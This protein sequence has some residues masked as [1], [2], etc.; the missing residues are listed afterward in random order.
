MKEKDVK[1]QQNFVIESFSDQETLSQYSNDALNI[2]LWESE[3]IFFTKYFPKDGR[4]LDIGCG[5]GR[6]TFG[7]YK[8]GYKNIIGVDLTPSM[9]E[10]ARKNSKKMGIDIG[11]EIGDACNL[12]YKDNS[13]GGCIFSFNGIMQ[14]PKIDNRVCAL[15][16]INR[17][18]IKDGISIFT[19]HDREAGTDWKWFWDEEKERWAKGEQDKRI[20][21]LG[22]R[23]VEDH[24]RLIFLHF[25]NREEVYNCIKESGLELVEDAW[26]PDITEEPEVVKKRISYC[27]FWVVKKP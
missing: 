6:T 23:I 10:E 14:I 19:T 20:F 26:L 18:L 27:R 13:F 8:L 4:I 9:I 11:F 1:V 7:L 5:A 16:E 21:E 3:K 22:D 2:G 17:V 24:G 25:P 15:K 12:P